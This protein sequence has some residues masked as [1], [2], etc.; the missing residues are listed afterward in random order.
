MLF[1]SIVPA[2]LPGVYNVC[3]ELRNN[4]VGCSDSM[5]RTLT[6]LGPIGYVTSIQN[7]VVC[8]GDQTSICWYTNS[9]TRP[10]LIYC[11]S[12]PIAVPYNPTNSYCA[13]HAYKYP[14]L[15]KNQI[16]IQDSAGCSY[17]LTDSV[18]VDKPIGGFNWTINGKPGVNGTYCGPI[19]VSFA[20][21]SKKTVYNLD[22]LSYH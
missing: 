13:T 4:S 5:C 3:M 11:D 12:L 9:F 20:D 6:V 1:R 19:T 21:T 2:K 7:R 18:V 17:P 10:N 8:A 22:P 14:G 15:C 16:W